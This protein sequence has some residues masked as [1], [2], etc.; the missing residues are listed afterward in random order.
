MNKTKEWLEN[1]KKRLQI[2][3]NQG[4]ILLVDIVGEER[5]MTYDLDELLAMVH[6]FMVEEGLCIKT[7]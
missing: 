5:L 1:N 4:N 3:T 6:E 7:V 2:Q